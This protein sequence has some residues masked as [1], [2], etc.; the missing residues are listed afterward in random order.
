MVRFILR[1]SRTDRIRLDCVRG[2][3][4][5]FAIGSAATSNR[6]RRHGKGP[7]ATKSRSCVPALNVL[8]GPR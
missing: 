5:P 7:S 2:G 4:L 1:T 6:V 8:T 3:S